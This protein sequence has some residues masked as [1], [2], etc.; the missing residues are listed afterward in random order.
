MT[1]ERPP[2]IK[3]KTTKQGTLYG[4]QP[5]G[6]DLKKA[7]ADPK[8]PTFLK[9]HALGYDML[10]AFEMADALNE[11]LNDWRQGNQVGLVKGSVGWLMNE[12]LKHPEVERLTRSSQDAY[13]RQ[14]RYITALKLKGGKKFSDKQLVEI[15]AKA[16]FNMHNKLISEHGPSTGNR[17]VKAIRY[18]WDLLHVIHEDYIPA[19]NPY[20]KIKLA[21]HSS[22]ETVPA[23]YSELMTAVSAA[24]SLGEIGLAFG[25]R[26]VWDFHMRGSEAFGVAGFHHW[27]PINRPSCLLVSS[28]K[29]GNPLWQPLDDP[30]TGDSMFPE[31]EALYKM[32]PYSEGKLCQRERQRGRTVY[33]G[34][35]QPM[36]YNNANK[37]LG[38]IAKKSGLGDHIRIGAF[39]H[40]GLTELGDAN[41]SR[42]LIKSRSNHK[43]VSTL[44]RYV[45]TNIEQ[46]VKAQKLR[47]KLREK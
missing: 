31:L 25:I 13:Q 3:T 2:N 42:D 30:E 14:A 40:G 11:R 6:R 29:T 34:D 43:Q 35:W 38:R 18:A 47:L 8:A 5:G 21:R 44:D 28:S 15:R 12:F 1:I 39:R 26:L 22:K 10:A 16:A 27:R 36:T 19:E 45:H 9:Y 32:L 46:A 41:V 37:V 24:I 20:A 4:W 23:T 7:K 17:C 33:A